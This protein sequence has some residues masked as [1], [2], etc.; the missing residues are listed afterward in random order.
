M[1]FLIFYLCLSIFI[2]C[3]SSN[4]STSTAGSVSTASYVFQTGAAITVKVYYEPNAAPFVGTTN[5][6][7][8][9][10]SVLSVN[11]TSI[12]Q[13]RSQPATITVPDELSEMTELTEQTKTSW[14]ATD[15]LSLSSQYSLDAPSSS[16]VYFK[17]FFLEGYYNN[18]TSDSTTTLGV[19]ITG[20]EVIAIFKDVIESSAV[21]PSGPIAK[22]VE[23]ST[24]V[25][26]MGHALGFVNNGV[27]MVNAHQD[28]A[29][30]AHTTNSS[31]VMYYLNEG[32]TDLKQ[33]INTYIN[34][35]SYIM[36][37][38]EVLADAENY[39]Q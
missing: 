26:E 32:A 24:L 3:G 5:S 7:L 22:F 38:T 19:H 15:I 18:G 17:I 12:L 16:H 13:Y 14:T 30:G 28:S 21:N 2:G 4:S 23:Q 9:L 10:W 1:R 27:A 35:S 37:G 11:L 31:C 6:G 36:W 29:N 8:N 25:H 33:F 39:S 34:T 20:T